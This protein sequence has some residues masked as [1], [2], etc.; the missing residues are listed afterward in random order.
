MKCY[1]HPDRE[2]VATCTECGKGLCKECA[3]KWEPCL[4]NDC[5]G[6]RLQSKRQTLKHSIMLG[7]VITIVGIVWGIVSAIQHGRADFLFMGIALGYAFGG[8]PNGWT[9]LSKIQ[10][11]MFLFLPAIGWF[12]YVFIKGFLSVIIGLFAFPLNIYRYIKESREISDM[13]KLLK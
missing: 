10:P 12:I 1:Y 4:C 11:S 13:E 7:V 5:A 3:S 6:E 2:I 8:I 9:A